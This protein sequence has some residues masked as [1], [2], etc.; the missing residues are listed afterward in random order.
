MHGVHNGKPRYSDA[1]AEVVGS[2]GTKIVIRLGWDQG[3]VAPD[4]NE[5]FQILTMR[6]GQIVTM[7]DYR[8]R[9]PALRAM[10]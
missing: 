2:T 4:R 6:D 9:R 10:T 7:R 8:R 5:L 3:T 1:R